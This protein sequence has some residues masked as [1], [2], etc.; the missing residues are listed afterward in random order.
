VIIFSWFQGDALHHE[1]C[2]Y[3]LTIRNKNKGGELWIIKDILGWVFLFEP[4]LFLF[5]KKC[6]DL[7]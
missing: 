2:G 5:I 4:A 7:G 6:C 1:D 3:I